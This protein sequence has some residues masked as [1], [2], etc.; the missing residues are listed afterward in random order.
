M[1]VSFDNLRAALNRGRQKSD[2]RT[3]RWDWTNFILVSVLGQRVVKSPVVPR[4]GKPEHPPST[5]RAPRPMLVYGAET[6][7]PSVEAAVATTRTMPEAP[8]W[9]VEADNRWF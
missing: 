6:S 4:P 8:L 3:S 5:V 2:F 9:P 1:D 7:L